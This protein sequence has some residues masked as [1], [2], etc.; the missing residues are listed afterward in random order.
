M[1]MKKIMILAVTAL[2]L[3]ACAK[4]YEVRETTPPEIGFGAWTEV[5]TKAS[6]DQGSSSFSETGKQ[7]NHFWVYGFKYISSN[8]EVFK[9]Q[10]VTTTN[11]TTW[12]YNPKR[13]WDSNATSYTFYALSR[14]E[15][16]DP[17]LAANKDA[18]VTD[19][20]F[21][22]MDIVFAGD[23]NDILVAKKAVVNKSAGAGN[24]DTWHTVDLD[25]HH[26]TSL[27][28]FKVKKGT[29]LEGSTVAITGA[30]LIAIP[31][32]GKY[33]ITYDGSNNPVAAW[34]DAASPATAAFDNTK[35]VGGTVT[36]PTNV[37]VH[38]NSTTGAD[39]ISGL[40]MRPHTLAN[41]ELLRISYTI[42]TGTDV[43]EFNNVDV[44]LNKFDSTDYDPSADP[45]DA[46]QNTTPF[47]TAWQQGKHYTYYLTIDAHSIEFTASITNW[48]PASGYHYLVN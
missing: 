28:D 40:I 31:S 23:D 11:G 43:I 35:G 3:A 15:S 17:T 26:I 19:G 9:S 5:L 14:V 12:T 25:F 33:S 44:Q 1:R 47:I 27:V 32:N 20:S 10:E 2:A 30:S 41:T 21:G 22:S 16:T 42:T 4:T 38:V 48:D 34:V 36:L 7:D 45:T 29:S 37:P 39:M 46:A 6:R 24:F 18:S 8:T 13:F